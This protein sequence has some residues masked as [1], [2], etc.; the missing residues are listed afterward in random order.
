MRT[1]PKNRFI[2]RV[3]KREC[4]TCGQDY[5]SSELMRQYDGIWACKDCFDP[6]HIAVGPY[7]M[8]VEPP[9]KRF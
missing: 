4:D 7:R 8:P 2:H 5:L 1:Y 9:F 6:K 3:F